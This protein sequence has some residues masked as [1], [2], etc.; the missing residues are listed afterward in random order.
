MPAADKIISYIEDRASEEGRINPYYMFE[1]FAVDKRTEAELAQAELDH[2]DLNSPELVSVFGKDPHPFQDGYCRDPS[3][4]TMLLAGTQSGKAL[5]LDADVYTKNG[6]VKMGDIRVGDMVLGPDGSERKVLTLHD[7]G[8]RPVYR[9]VFDD[10]SECKCDIDHLWKVMFKKNAS[11][12]VWWRG[13]I[14]KNQKHEQWDVVTLRDIIK[15]CGEGEI[16]E[17]KR[18]IFPVV[19]R[20]GFEKKDHLI[21]PYAMGAILGDGGISQR[22]AAITIHNDDIE[23]INRI[24]A[25]GI[26][27][28]KRAGK[29]Q[30]G[31]LGIA[32]EL[33]RLGLLGKKSATKFI[34]DEY[35]YT[36]HEDRVALLR[37]LMD[38]DGSISSGCSMEISVKGERLAKDIVWLVR[39]IGGKASL[40]IR[41]SYY[42]KDGKRT[43]C[44]VSHR[45][46]VKTGE[47][48]PFA[49][50]RKAD[51]FFVIQHRKERHLR[52]IERVD[53]DRTRCF[54]LD[55]EDGL[56]LTNDFCVTHNSYTAL[57]DMVIQLTHEIPF[58]LKLEAGDKS[59]MKRVVNKENVI[60]FGRRN[61]RTGEIIDYDWSIDHDSTWDCGYIEGV[62]KYPREKL[63]PPG[64]K[65]WLCTFKQA[66]D[67]YWWPKF[68]SLPEH[69]LDVRKGNKGFYTSDGYIVYLNRGCEIHVITYEQGYERVEAEKV[70]RIHLDE[71]PPDERFFTAAVTHCHSL[72][73][74]MTP[75]RGLTFTYD[76]IFK[77]AAD[78][79]SVR[80]Y[81]CTQ[82]D[83]PYHTLE[84]I[85]RARKYMDAWTVGARVYGLH[86]EQVGKPYYDRVAVTEKMRTEYVPL[87]KN[88]DIIPNRPW[89][90]VGE[91]LCAGVEALENESGDWEIYED[92]KEDGAYW[93]SVDTADGA[94]NPEEAGD[95]SCAHIFRLPLGDEKATRPV[96]VACLHSSLPTAEFARLVLYGALYYNRALIAPEV[97]GFSAATFLS[98]VRDYPFLFTMSVVNDKTRKPTNKVGF[99]TTSKNRTLLFDL[100][101]NWL[102]DNEGD[103]HY[104]I[105]HFYTLKE[106]AGCVVGKKGRPDHT[107]DGSTDCLFAFGIGLYV[108]A[109]SKDQ[110]HNRRKREKKL[111]MW[112]DRCYKPEETRPVLGSNRGIDERTKQRD[113]IHPRVV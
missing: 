56:F 108:F 69:L 14:K 87:H 57:I 54:T 20:A 96:H 112:G 8:V 97:I 92:C 89:D 58:S 39:S 24:S 70:W 4:M 106:I 63:A 19:W 21:S 83:S 45:I 65:I 80:I 27:V 93:V 100:V 60:R 36:S 50:K 30:W 52:K 76:K 41:D 43:D 53:D 86:T 16:A 88:V 62:G 113:N 75:Y 61:S 82:Y 90:R 111:D 105:N 109:H 47:I 15:R 11:K 84:S 26:T 73:L 23:I 81:H 101:G 77:K 78:K 103:R 10:G 71:E 5:P 32:G 51:R 6:P 107:R 17:H 99:S 22:G 98:E 74:T 25:G 33:S 91:L 7:Q 34:P 95:K 29:Y 31:L 104:A 55:A 37:G 12:H 67:E 18:P 79:Q 64:S 102:K 9:L 49:L 2:I 85:N 72:S 35:K 110:I 46:H 94:E 68:K 40:S 1:P 42:L 38:T 3:F 44:G 13:K 66:R 28:S 59:H 48:N